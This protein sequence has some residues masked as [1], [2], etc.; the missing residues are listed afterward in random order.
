MWV[1]DSISLFDDVDAKYQ[2]WR[3]KQNK[4]TK[5]NKKKQNIKMGG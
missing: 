1:K 2:T 4:K 3:R 5:T